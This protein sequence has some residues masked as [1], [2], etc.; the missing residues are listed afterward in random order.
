MRVQ[1]ATR[2][3]PTDQVY[4]VLRTRSSLNEVPTQSLGRELISAVASS[5]LRRYIYIHAHSDGRKYDIDVRG[6][7][8]GEGIGRHIEATPSGQNT[9]SS[10]SRFKHINDATQK[11]LHTIYQPNLELML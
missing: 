7:G 11:T 10:Y 8:S 3:N 5:S 4:L 6:L 9:K 2:P 1:L